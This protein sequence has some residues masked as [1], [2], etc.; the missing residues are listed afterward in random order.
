MKVLFLPVNIAS[1][2][3]LTTQ[4]LNQ[5]DGVEAMCITNHLSVLNTVGRNTLFIPKKIPRKKP[6]HW[7]YHK[8]TYRQKI[9]KWIRWA[10]VLHYTWSPAFDDGADLQVA[11]QLNKPVFIEWVGSDIRD[12]VYL[13]SINP[14]YAHAFDNGYEYHELES[15]NHRMRVLQQFSSVGAQPLVNPEMS[16]YVDREFFP[17]GVHR[18]MPRINVMDLAPSYPEVSTKRPLV[19]HSPSARV[20]KGTQYVLEAVDALHKEYDFDFRLIENLPRSEALKLMATCDVFIDQ[21]IL[22]SYGLASIEAMS[23]GKPV[24]CYIMPQVFEA[25]LSKACPIVNANPDTLKSQLARLLADGSLRSELGRKGRAF[26][27]QQHDAKVIGKQLVTLYK[28]AFKNTRKP[29]GE[30]S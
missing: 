29:E 20:C 8:L 23:F 17:G 6:I 13:S 21:L 18:L 25:G 28:A 19:I 11:K 1:F 7:L 22:G 16:L 30:S 3:F 2:P 15:S 14:Y 10:D 4:A 12:H 26:A 24:L 9:L 27:E 5:L